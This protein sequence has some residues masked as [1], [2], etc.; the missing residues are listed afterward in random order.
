[1]K[2]ITNPDWNKA[3]HIFCS[4]VGTPLNTSN[5]W[6][7]FTAL[8]GR[9]GLVTPCA[10]YG[11]RGS[12]A[13]GSGPQMQRFHPECH[14]GRKSSE[15]GATRERGLPRPDVARAGRLERPTNG[16]EDRCSIH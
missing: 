1:M 4:E 3:D 16:L 14:P 5:I 12:S 13:R 6:R 8:Q 15:R 11:R 2:R 9:C 7:Q 10:D